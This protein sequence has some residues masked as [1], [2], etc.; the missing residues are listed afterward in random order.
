[1]ALTGIVG[2]VDELEVLNPIPVAEVASWVSASATALLQPTSGD[3]FVRR[4]ERRS[5]NWLPERAWG[6]R[7]RNR[8]V[9]NLASEARWLTIPAGA[10]GTRDIPADALTAVGVAATHRRRGLLR[11]M[12]TSSLAAAKDRGDAVSILIAA[13][14]PIYGRFG[15]APASV[16][17]D[18]LLRPR[19]SEPLLSPPAGVLRTVDADELTPIARGLFGTARLL[20]PGQVDRHDPW[21]ARRLG[22]D[23]YATTEPEPT[24]ILHEGAAGADGMLGWTVR[25]DFGLNDNLGEVEVLDF[26]ATGD[27]AYRDLWA[28][29][30]GIDAV[31]AIVLR[32]RPVDEPIRWLLRD[33]RALAQQT[34][35]DFLWVR[36]LDVPAALSARGYAVPGRVVLDVVDGAVSGY[37]AGR[38]LLEAGAEDAM[39]VRSDEP[40]DLRIDQRALAAIYLGGHRLRA[41]AF[42][43]GVEELSPGSLD[44]VDAMFGT[45][46]APWTQTG[47]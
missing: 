11:R 29:L 42:G 12:I 43:G 32:G 19:R 5:R 13:E 37:G 18:Y 44:R 17:C 35:S 22:Q 7:D 26:V 14:W 4:V 41:V 6:V 45:N 15:Y 21:W 31:E 34:V 16:G 20:R 25:R 38:V 23:G 47:F 30:C 2:H 24:W 8:W 3:D 28:Y 1:M 36:L 33:G 39:C 9:A 27:D 46:L 40:A 10:T